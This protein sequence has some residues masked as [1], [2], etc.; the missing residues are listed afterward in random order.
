[1]QNKEEI[2]IE[3]KRTKK[4]TFCDR[5]INISIHAVINRFTLYSHPLVW[6][7][8]NRTSYNL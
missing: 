6:R 2:N 7:R 5:Q 4:N 1:M 3:S 8:G